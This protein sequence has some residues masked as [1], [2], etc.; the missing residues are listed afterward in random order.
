MDPTIVEIATVIGAAAGVVGVLVAIW[1]H[2]RRDKKRTLQGIT[3]MVLRTAPPKIIA[4]GRPS[5]VEEV[6]R[7]VDR[8][9]L[10]VG[11]GVQ[12][13]RI[14]EADPGRHRLLRMVDTTS[15]GKPESI[16]V[17]TDAPHL[18]DGFWGSVSA[19]AQR[20]ANLERQYVKTEFLSKV[21]A[22]ALAMEPLGLA[23]ARDRG[24]LKELIAAAPEAFHRS[25][26][27]VRAAE[28]SPEMLEFYRGNFQMV[29]TPGHIGRYIRLKVLATLCQDIEIKLESPR[30]LERIGPAVENALQGV[31]GADVERDLLAQAQSLSDLIKSCHAVLVALQALDIRVRN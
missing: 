9:A 21:T 16:V 27:L 8:I 19:Y 26:L 7:Q 2:F 13:I 18:N 25:V 12:E 1:L 3:E 4:K 10:L 30:L 22:V 24:V 29:V 31:T 11:I 20:L 28:G 15:V 17:F 6:E 23:L 14:I 5:F